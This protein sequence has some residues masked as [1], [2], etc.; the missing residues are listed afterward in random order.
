[1]FIQKYDIR[2]NT[3]KKAKRKIILGN[4]DLVKVICF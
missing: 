4:D 3:S 1:M 2:S